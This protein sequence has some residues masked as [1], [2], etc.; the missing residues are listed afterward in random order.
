M[1]DDKA[2]RSYRRPQ[3]KVEE[4]PEI[5]PGEAY[6]LLAELVDESRPKGT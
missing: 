4:T 5:F 3:P 1:G 6:D 2:R